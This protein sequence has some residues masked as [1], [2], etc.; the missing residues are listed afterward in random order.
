MFHECPTQDI[1]DTR[2]H[3]NIVVTVTQHIGD[4]PCRFGAHARLYDKRSITTDQIREVSNY[5][6]IQPKALIMTEFC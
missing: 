5:D 6:P 4:T 3:D 1:V 2:S